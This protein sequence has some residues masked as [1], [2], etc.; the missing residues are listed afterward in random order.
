[1][2]T[3]EIEKLKQELYE[4][5]GI[6]EI[7]KQLKCVREFAKKIDALMPYQGIVFSFVNNQIVDVTPPA[8]KKTIISE[9]IRNIYFMLHTELMFNACVSAEESSFSA[10][11]ACI[12]AAVAAVTSVVGAIAT[13]ITIFKK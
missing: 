1:M 5:Q 9:T 3:K 11:W 2:T 7:E 10:K 12:C 13:W 4:I 6:P 8:Q